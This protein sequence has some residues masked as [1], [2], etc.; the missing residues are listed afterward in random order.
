MV[1]L[2]TVIE[3]MKV[4]SATVATIVSCFKFFLKTLEILRCDVS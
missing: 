1:S 2:V 3:L 4:F